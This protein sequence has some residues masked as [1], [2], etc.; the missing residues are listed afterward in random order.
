MIEGSLKRN[1][2]FFLSD[3]TG[4]KAR[5]CPVWQGTN[6]EDPNRAGCHEQQAAEARAPGVVM[7]TG[8]RQLRDLDLSALQEAEVRRRP[9]CSG[10]AWPLLRLPVL[11]GP[12]RSSFS[13]VRRQGFRLFLG[14]SKDHEIHYLYIRPIPGQR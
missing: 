7:F 12:D 4:A 3:A 6:P 13:T 11:Q 2:D 9:C 1:L 10:D 8:W 14:V 5:T